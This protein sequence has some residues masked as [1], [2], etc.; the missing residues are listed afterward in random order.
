MRPQWF[1]NAHLMLKMFTEEIPLNQCINVFMVY[2]EGSPF[3]SRFCILY[4]SLFVLYH[5]DVC[6][7]E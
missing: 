1:L 5:L 7:Q 4:Y 6:V 2:F 3:S